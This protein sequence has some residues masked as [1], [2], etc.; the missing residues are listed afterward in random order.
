MTGPD[1]SA[2]GSSEPARPGDGVRRL[3]AVMDRLRSPGGCPWDAQQ[4][5]ESLVPF[6]L[7]EAHEVAE[8]IAWLLSDAASYVTGATLDVSGGR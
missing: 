3:V 1:P 8:A 5:H 6:V 7:E 4:T 2:D